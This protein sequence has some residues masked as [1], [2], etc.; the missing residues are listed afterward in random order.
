[1]T[2]L[3]DHTPRHIA[4]LG[5]AAAMIAAFLRAVGSFLPSARETPALA[6][7]YLMTD[8][9]ILLGLIGWY[10]AQ[11]RR[12]GPRGLLGFVLSVVGV[13]VIRSNG[14]FPGIDTYSIGAPLL[15]IGLLVLAASAWRAS[16]MGAWVPAALVVAGVL[17]P[18]GYL[19]PGVSALFAASGLAFSIGF[20]GAGTYLWRAEPRD[21]QAT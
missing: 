8:V 13:V 1:M 14:D 18:V 20:G 21:C 16:L 6:G 3:V 7:L 4:R 12:L 2:A 17:G 15:V 19:A 5:G 11:R 10:L 9:L